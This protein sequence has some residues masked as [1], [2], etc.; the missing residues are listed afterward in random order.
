MPPTHAKYVSC[1]VADTRCVGSAF[2]GKYI[3]HLSSC[4][5]RVAISAAADTLHYL[6]VRGLY[7]IHRSESSKRPMFF[8]SELDEAH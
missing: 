5:R 1:V 7:P 4:E 2:V 6:P 8:V 3:A